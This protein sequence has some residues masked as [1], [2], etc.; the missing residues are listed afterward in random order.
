MKHLSLALGIIAFALTVCVNVN[1]QTA[2]LVASPAEQARIKPLVVA[3]T[4]AREALLAKTATLPESTTLKAAKEA[5]DKAL[6]QLNK[7][8]EKLPEH[9]AWKEAGARA[10]DEAY[11]IQ[12]DHKLS[13]REYKPELNPK[14]DLVFV[15]IPVS[16]ASAGTAPT[17]P[18][19]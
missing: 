3:E 6:E 18:K 14:E 9:A 13:S 1:G 19:P 5:Y 7:A 17:P 15:K 8:T 10:L 12:A 4:K 16:V 2:P 11:R